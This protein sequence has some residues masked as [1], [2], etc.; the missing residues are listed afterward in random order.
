MKQE[1]FQARH[2]AEWTR[3]EHWLDARQARQRQQRAQADTIMAASEFPSALRR[4]CQQLAVAER[5]DYSTQLVADLRGLAQRGHQVL[6]RPRP[7]RLRLLFDFLAAG[8]PRLVR[9][10]GACMAAAA[11][12]FFVP[13]IAVAILL[14][15]HPELIHSLFDSRQLAQFENMYNPLHHADRLGRDGGADLQMFGVYVFNNV[16]IGFR[17]FASGLLA[18]VGAVFVL[19]FNGIIIGGVAG[20]LTAIGYGGP[21]WDFV[22]GHSAPELLAIVIAGGAGLHIGMALLAPGRRSRA[23]ALAEAGVDGAKLV[24]GVFAMLVLA[25]F[26]EAY[27]SSI[28]WLPSTLKHAVGLALWSLLLLW[29]WRGGR[30]PAPMHADGGADASG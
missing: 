29:L 28:V 15:W 27:W 6:Y 11:A 19:V 3:F 13:L 9:A 4:L 2:G 25:A 10:Q 5:R 8:F 1:A 12:L 21:F 18:G 26:I 23:R 16:S 24:L 14:Q 17:T 20:H 7:P 30:S 22:A